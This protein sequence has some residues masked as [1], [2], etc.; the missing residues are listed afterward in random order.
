METFTPLGRLCCCV[1]KVDKARLRFGLPSLSQSYPWALYTEAVTAFPKG[2]SHPKPWLEQLGTKQANISRLDTWRRGSS[3]RKINHKIKPGGY[4]I[5]WSTS[6]EHPKEEICM[7]ST[8][9][10][11]EILQTNTILQKNSQHLFLQKVKLDKEAP[12][13]LIL[14]DF[15]FWERFLIKRDCLLEKGLQIV[16]K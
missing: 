15:F 9:F 10:K 8:V 12:G 5:R 1:M 14:W 2:Q 16:K 4:E 13:G 11:T 6:S 3:I 7:Q